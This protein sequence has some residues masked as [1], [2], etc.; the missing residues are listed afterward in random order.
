MIPLFLCAMWLRHL[1]KQI[2]TKTAYPE[3]QQRSS[4]GLWNKHES[5]FALRTV[6]FNQYNYRPLLKGCLILH[7]LILI[8]AMSLVTFHLQSE[9]DRKSEPAQ[10]VIAQICDKC[11][12]ESRSVQMRRR[13]K[14]CVVPFWYTDTG[15]STLEYSTETPKV[16][17]LV[18]SLDCECCYL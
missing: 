12:I 18:C 5:R 6:S 9:V 17:F 1:G 3:A 4:K 7:F 2:T 14:S 13:G 15:K 16:E 8:A 10:L 11:V